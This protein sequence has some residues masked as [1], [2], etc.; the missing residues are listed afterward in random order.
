MVAITSCC[1]S[2]IATTLYT[3]MQ[4]FREV[5]VGSWSCSRKSADSRNVAG[6]QRCTQSRHVSSLQGLQYV[7]SSDDA[8]EMNRLVKEEPVITC[9]DGSRATPDIEGVHRKSKQAAKFSNSLRM[10]ESSLDLVD[11]VDQEPI[12]RPPCSLGRVSQNGYENFCMS[13]SETLIR[14]SHRGSVF[15]PSELK[16][17]STTSSVCKSTAGDGQS[18][19]G[20]LAHKQSLAVSVRPECEERRVMRDHKQR[21]RRRVFV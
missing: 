2:N 21:S 16:I 15:L 9:I 20:G 7:S 19:L 12:T 3:T 18:F 8:P 11:K 13:A 4:P 14:D 5:Q 10:I 6:L 1:C 17:C